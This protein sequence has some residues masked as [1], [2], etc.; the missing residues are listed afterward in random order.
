MADNSPQA[1]NAAQLKAMADNGSRFVAQRFID[2]PVQ[3][4]GQQEEEK[5]LGSR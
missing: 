2:K 4:Q 3:L 1:A 5:D